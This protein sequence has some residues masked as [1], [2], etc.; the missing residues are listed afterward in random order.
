MNSE[1]LEDVIEKH[2]SFKYFDYTEEEENN[3][4]ESIIKRSD[5]QQQVIDSNS[6]TGV[7]PN[8][9]RLIG[10]VNHLGLSSNSGHY[11][12]DVYNI[13]S[14]TWISYDDTKVKAISEEHVLRQRAK[15]GYIFF[16][17]HNSFIT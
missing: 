16:Y 1:K 13:K 2:F 7:E 17:I 10:I 15:T 4:G 5:E 9:Y 11:I 8:S 3:S 12:S 6:L 14:K